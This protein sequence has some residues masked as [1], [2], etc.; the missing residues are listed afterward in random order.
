ME[1]YIAIK[2]KELMN[3]DI[4]PCD[5]FIQ[6]APD[7]YIKVFLEDDYIELEDIF[8]YKG[9]GVMHLFIKSEDNYKW[10]KVVSYQLK[11]KISNKSLDNDKSKEEY[12]LDAFAKSRELVLTLGLEEETVEFIKTVQDET[13]HSLKKS[14]LSIN[15]LAR[16]ISK[17]EFIASQ[18]FLVATISCATAIKMSWS[19]KKTLQQ[20]TL[21]GLFHDITLSN[22]KVQKV[23]VQAEFPS[24]LLE[25]DIEDFLTHP[26]AAKELFNSLGFKAPS[27]EEIILYHH[28]LP[29]GSGFP[30][31]LN[32]VALPPHVCLFI[33]CEEIASTLLLNDF[34]VE[35]WQIIRSRFEVF[36]NYGNFKTPLKGLK[37]LFER[38]L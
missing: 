2:T 8:K 30:R 32:S 25:K 38:L 37:S 7:K 6:L 1:D 20:F 13:I 12:I 31:G 15:Y 16:M 3:G 26:V 5:I 18:S 22:Q 11:R 19:T 36:Y 27:I 35:A 21:A 24:E 9:K 17:N 28:E 29:D 34:K 4:Y 14:N 10:Q 23:R 33:L